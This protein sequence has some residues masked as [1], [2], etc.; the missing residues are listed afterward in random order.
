VDS[1]FP[2]I[3]IAALILAR[4]HVNSARAES[5]GSARRL[6]VAPLAKP[7]MREDWNADQDREECFADYT[8]GLHLL[9]HRRFERV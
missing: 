4:Q 6:I 8:N 2:P 1:L 3:V 5:S 9:E 7:N